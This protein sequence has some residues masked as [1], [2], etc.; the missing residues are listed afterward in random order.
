MI[1]PRSSTDRLAHNAYMNTYMKRRYARRRAQAVEQLGGKCVDCG[2]AGFVEFDHVDPEEKEA[3]ISR[4]LAGASWE[5]LQ[6][7]LVKCVL[8][9]IA[10]HAHMTAFQR[11]QTVDVLGTALVAEMV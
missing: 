10:C 11:L 7:E 9:C 2:F 5:K 3:N 8:R 1:A 6:T 4:L